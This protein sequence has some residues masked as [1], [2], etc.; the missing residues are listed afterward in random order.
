[1]RTVIPIAVWSLVLLATFLA[2]GIGNLA[3]VWLLLLGLPWS[4]I[5]TVI[6]VEIRELP[7]WL[8]G[9]LVVGSAYV[10]ATIV[11]LMCWRNAGKKRGQG[12]PLINN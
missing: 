12:Q 5:A 2:Y 7:G 10:N 11:S 9:F 4:L 6:D 1:M 3:G 8:D